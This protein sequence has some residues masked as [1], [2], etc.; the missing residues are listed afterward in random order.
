MKISSDVINYK[1]IATIS[2]L[3]LNV[4]EIDDLIE[5]FPDE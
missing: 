2:F 1:Y 4:F 5:L 3:S